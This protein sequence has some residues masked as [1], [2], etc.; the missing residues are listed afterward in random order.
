MEGGGSLGP[1]ASSEL[2]RLLVESQGEPHSAT[3]AAHVGLGPQA[4]ECSLARRLRRG[5][6]RGSL[7]PQALILPPRVPCS[8]KRGQLKDLLPLVLGTTRS[9]SPRGRTDKRRLSQQPCGFSGSGGQHVSTCSAP[10]GHRVSK[11]R[12][13][14]PR[15]TARLAQEA[16]AQTS[17][18][19]GWTVVPRCRADR[20]ACPRGLRAFRAP[21][22]EQPVAAE[23]TP[24]P[25]SGPPLPH[26]QMQEK[27]GLVKSQ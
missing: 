4:P 2:L 3:H 9:E 23:A 11:D 1:A 22:P 20:T 17:S 7:R 16:K 19:L 24:M 5:C 21:C 25:S 26:S 14:R 27:R 10:G 6:C 8:A 18:S 13:R 15:H 12:A